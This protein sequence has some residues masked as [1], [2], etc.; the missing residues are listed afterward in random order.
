MKSLNCPHAPS[1]SAGSCGTLVQQHLFF[2][3]VHE[4]ARS[5]PGNVE[6]T[7]VLAA[8]SW[9]RQARIPSATLNT[10]K[11]MWRRPCPCA[12]TAAVMYS[13]MSQVQPPMSRL[14]EIP[15][16]NAHMQGRSHEGCKAGLACTIAHHSI[17]GSDV[18]SDAAPEFLR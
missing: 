10:Y 18:G 3:M 13:A 17:I 8:T 11:Q 15:S 16:R 12:H 6:C 5:A 1:T 9:R 14:R 2:I 4:P 7:V